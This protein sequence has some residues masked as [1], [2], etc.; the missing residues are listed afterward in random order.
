[1]LLCK[2]GNLSIKH[3]G[4][5]VID[6]ISYIVVQQTFLIACFCKAVARYCSYM[7]PTQMSPYSFMNLDL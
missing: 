1:M 4:L 5:F 3:T 2:G 6:D 7:D